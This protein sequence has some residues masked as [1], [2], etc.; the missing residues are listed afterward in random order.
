MILNFAIYSISQSSELEAS[1]SSRDEDP[2]S[3]SGSAHGSPPQR[4]FVALVLE[5]VDWK[6]TGLVEQ[7]KQHERLGALCQ[8]ANA[9]KPSLGYVE[10]NSGHTGIT[11]DMVQADGDF[12]S[13]G[14]VFWSLFSPPLLKQA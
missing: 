7:T 14:V 3:S 12:F 9:W 2:Q 11:V 6:H 13:P 8:P 5:W 4:G 1:W 10:E